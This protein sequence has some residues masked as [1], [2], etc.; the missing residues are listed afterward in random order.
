MKRKNILFLFVVSFLAFTFVIIP[1]LISQEQ[2]GSEKV[3]ESDKGAETIDV[4]TYP[5][6]MQEYYTVFF[7]KCSRCHTLARPINTD[8]TLDKW[9]RY[10]KRMMRKPGS[11]ITKST[12]KKIFEFLKYYTELKKNKA[13]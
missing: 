11:G 5:E 1:N 7:K 6:Q 10:V 12:G 2:T 3:F 9:E 13:I 8:F 4:S